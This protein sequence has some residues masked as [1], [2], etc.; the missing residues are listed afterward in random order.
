MIAKLTRLWF[1]KKTKETNV[2]SGGIFIQVTHGQ[3]SI[4]HL[5]VQSELSGEAF[6]SL[7]TDTVLRTNYCLYLTANLNRVLTGCLFSNHT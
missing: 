2:F 6:N 4:D 5:K 3:K 7:S 1:K